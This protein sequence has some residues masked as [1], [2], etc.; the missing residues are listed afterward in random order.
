MLDQSLFLSCKLLNDKG[1]RPGVGE[2]DEKLNDLTKKIMEEK[3][4]LLG[5]DL[6]KE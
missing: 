1:E 4:K 5:K 3:I 6:K 2:F